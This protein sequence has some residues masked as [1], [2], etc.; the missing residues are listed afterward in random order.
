MLMLLMMMMMRRRL[1]IEWHRH[2]MI[3]ISM[4]IDIVALLE[5]VNDLLGGFHVRH[6]GGLQ[7]QQLNKIIY[8]D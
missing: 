4:L 6:K 8:I 1:Q 2:R 7:L 3:L 5:V